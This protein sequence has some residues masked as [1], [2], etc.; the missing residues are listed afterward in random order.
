[1]FLNL[2]SVK[3]LKRENEEL[4]RFYAQIVKSSATTSMKPF[5]DQFFEVSCL[6]EFQRLLHDIH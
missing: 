1:M 6:K 4:K 2:C 3:L 5:I